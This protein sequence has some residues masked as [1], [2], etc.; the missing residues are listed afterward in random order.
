MISKRL[1]LVGTA[2]TCALILV[3]WGWTHDG[4]KHATEKKHHNL[5]GTITRIDPD[6][7]TFEIQ[8]GRNKV[9]LCYLD[10]K[11]RI[12][13]DGKDIRLQDIKEGERV[14]CKCAEHTGG[15]HYSLELLVE[16]PKK[17]R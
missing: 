4:R 14:L 15:R 8:T 13:R 5:R 7:H 17:T 9:V 3:A 6:A 11:S 16:L 2:T 1:A 12:H 10:A